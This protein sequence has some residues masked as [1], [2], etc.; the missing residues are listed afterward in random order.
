MVSDIL[1]SIKPQFCPVYYT[2]KDE[3][4]HLPK[5]KT[6]LRLVIKVACIDSSE[7]LERFG[8]LVYLERG[9]FVEQRDL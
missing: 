4:P 1:L 7:S 8:C 9:T 5:A 2:Q 3:F 6:D